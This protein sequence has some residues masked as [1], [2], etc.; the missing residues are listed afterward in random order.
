MNKLTSIDDG[1]ISGLLQ[2]EGLSVVLMTSPWD[3]NGIILRSI[4]EN[5]TAQFPAVQFRVADYEA[6]PRLARLFN[7]MS[8]PGI[9]LI[10]AGEMIQRVTGPVSAGRISD[11]IREAA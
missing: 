7:L 9:L 6:S 3:G 4:I 11:L 10:K 2:A 1:Q 5:L 8:P